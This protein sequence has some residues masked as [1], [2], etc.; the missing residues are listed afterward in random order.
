MHR[1]TTQQLEIQLETADK[2]IVKFEEETKKLKKKADD[3]E[4]RYELAE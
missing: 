2:K 3:L 4:V 1:K